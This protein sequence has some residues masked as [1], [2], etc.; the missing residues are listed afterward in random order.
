M[1]IVLYFTSVSSNMEVSIESIVVVN[2]GKAGAYSEK[3][4]LQY[5]VDK[6]KQNTT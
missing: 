1:G 3:K 5:L 4:V 6:W 2:P